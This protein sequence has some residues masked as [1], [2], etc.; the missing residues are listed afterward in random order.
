M[1][2][3]WW[4]ASTEKQAFYRVYRIGQEKETQMTRILVRNSIDEAIMAL[5][6][7]KELSIDAVMELGREEKVSLPELMQLFG[8]VVHDKSGRPYIFAEGEVNEADDENTRPPGYAADCES[9]AEGDG[10]VDDD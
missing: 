10:M 5:Q 2:A 8:K 6:D 1:C 7:K 3:A 9:D 4:N